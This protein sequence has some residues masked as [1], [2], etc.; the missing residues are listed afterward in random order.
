VSLIPLINI[1]RE[2]LREFSK[3]LEMVL[4]GYS[5]AQETLIY[6]KT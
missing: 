1:I 6:E 5:G 3:K 2:Y 4:M